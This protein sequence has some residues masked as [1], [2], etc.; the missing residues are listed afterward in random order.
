MSCPVSRFGCPGVSHCP[1]PY[2]ECEPKTELR[3]IDVLV[4]KQRR[5]EA[6]E[7]EL[8]LLNARKLVRGEGAQT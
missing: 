2:V 1:S 8:A 5:I 3:L 4:S 6:L 7:R